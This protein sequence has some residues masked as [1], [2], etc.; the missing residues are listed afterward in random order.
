[1]NKIFLEDELNYRGFIETYNVSLKDG[2]LIADIYSNTNEFYNNHCLH[3]QDF[4]SFLDTLKSLS[5]IN[6]IYFDNEFLVIVTSSLP[7]ITKYI[8][9]LRNI[10]L[11][12]DV[13]SFIK[14]IEE[15]ISNKNENLISKYI[16]YISKSIKGI[17][18]PLIKNGEI[19]DLKDYY[20]T[21]YN[22]IR[23]KKKV[24]GDNI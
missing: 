21:V 17:N 11:N 10:E 5:F 2:K 19:N 20:D 1:M 8:F 23:D 22:T 18:V 3:N 7:S 15:K 9:D 6:S 24:K 12:D 14:S 4:L 16:P 13:I